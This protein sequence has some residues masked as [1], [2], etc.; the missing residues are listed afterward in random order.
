MKKSLIFLFLLLI[1]INF[2]SAQDLLSD[3]LNTLDESMVILSAI[4]IIS[5]IL[6]FFSLNKTLFK[7]EKNNSMAA[8]ISIV[9]AFLITYGINKSGFD[10]SGFFFNIGIS[11]ETFSTIIPFVILAGIIVTIIF[12]KSKSLFV[13]GGLLIFLSFFIYAKTLF[14]VIGIILLVVGIF[15]NLKKKK[16]EK[17]I[18]IRL[19]RP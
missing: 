3:L 10:V 19:G 16:E 13:F 5:F 11:G 4:F 17:G 18:N 2:V 1:A 8:I 14:I 9:L 12:L 7:R 15:L 6:L